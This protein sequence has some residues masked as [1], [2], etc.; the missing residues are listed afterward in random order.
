M[1]LLFLHVLGLSYIE[2]FFFSHLFILY[3]IFKTISF[4]NDKNANSGSNNTAKRSSSSNSIE[5]D[6][7]RR[8]SWQP[9][10]FGNKNP[11]VSLYRGK[12]IVL[13]LFFTG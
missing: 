12:F 13:D 10:I 3:F 5:R 4:K 6:E 7:S 2:M 9:F 1:L 11:S 8:A